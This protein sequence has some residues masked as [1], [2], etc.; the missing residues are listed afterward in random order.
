MTANGRKRQEVKEFPPIENTL[1]TASLLTDLL[2]QL[3]MQTDDSLMRRN[4][5]AIIGNFDDD[6]YLVASFDELAAMGSWPVKSFQRA[7]K[8]SRASIRRAAARD[9]A[10]TFL[11]FQLHNWDSATPRLMVCH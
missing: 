11:L 2:P 8:S 4:R 1:S 10:G 9:L 5:T 6:G 3:S 7:L